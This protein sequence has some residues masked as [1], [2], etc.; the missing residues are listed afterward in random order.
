MINNFKNYIV[1]L[2]TDLKTVPKEM[3]KNRVLRTGDGSHKFSKLKDAEAPPNN[4]NT[5]ERDT[6]HFWGWGK[7]YLEEVN[8]SSFNY[9]VRFFY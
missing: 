6:E 7:R 9:T 2:A 1:G 3:I 4:N 8:G 5:G